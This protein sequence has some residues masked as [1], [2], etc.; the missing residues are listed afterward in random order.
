MDITWYFFMILVFLMTKTNKTYGVISSKV[1]YINYFFLAIVIALSG[2]G[3]NGIIWAALNFDNISLHFKD[4]LYM[5]LWLNIFMWIL[6]HLVDCIA[7]LLAY[8]MIQRNEKA[9]KLFIIILPLSV[10]TFSY[11]MVNKLHDKIVNSSL[12]WYIGVSIAL[13]LASIV[14]IPMYFFYRSKKIKNLL[15]IVE[16]KTPK[17]EH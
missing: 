12:E 6:L 14:Y 11:E 1:Q 5:P 13:A 3:F 16:N 8:Y 15:F 4:Y 7:L 10:V 2:F 17:I 9:R